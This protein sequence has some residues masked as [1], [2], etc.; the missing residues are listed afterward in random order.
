MK[1]FPHVFIALALSSS[2]AFAQSPPLVSSTPAPAPGL[3]TP[4]VLTKL[5]ATTGYTP[6]KKFSAPGGLTGW[7]M[8]K[9]P[10]QN[11]VVYTPADE[12]I[13]IV[14][15]LLAPDGKNITREH[16]DAYGVKVDYSAALSTLSALPSNA[17][18]A[19]TPPK[20]TTPNGNKLFVFLDPNCG[21]CHLAYKALTPYVNAG[22]T[23]HWVPVAFLSKDSANKAAFLLNA[24]DK[25]KALEQL[26]KHLDNRNDPTLAAS[27]SI[28]PSASHSSILESNRQHMNNFGFSGTPAFIYKHSS[29]QARGLSGMP[30]PESIPDIVGMPLLPNTQK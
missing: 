18:I 30:S 12:S 10:G 5:I 21:Y 7:A 16:A 19:Q 3:S 26:A 4:A 15:N 13:A 11:I 24:P 9:G 29:G 1:N 22:L 6:V 23:V 2:A 27:V 8:T 25:N 28:T 17:T 14:G 20:G